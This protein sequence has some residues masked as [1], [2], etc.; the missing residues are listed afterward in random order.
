MLESKNSLGENEPLKSNSFK[1]ESKLEH[2]LSIET[3]LNLINNK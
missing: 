2:N 1:I 3:N